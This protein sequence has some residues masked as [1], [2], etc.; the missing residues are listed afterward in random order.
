[1]NLLYVDGEYRAQIE[2]TIEIS[3]EFVKQRIFHAAHTIILL[4]FFRNK[5]LSIIF[6]LFLVHLIFMQQKWT[7]VALTVL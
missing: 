6:L 7:V 1:M 4:A 5:H 2:G 3:E